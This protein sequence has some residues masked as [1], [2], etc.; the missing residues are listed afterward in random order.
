M[1]CVSIDVVRV[2]VV[3][4]YLLFCKILDVFVFIVLFV[5][6]FEFVWDKV[7]VVNCFWIVE[8]DGLCNI[9]DV[10]ELIFFEVCLLFLDIIIFMKLKVILWL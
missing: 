1:D 6:L 4:L 7:E 3:L 5:C 8:D 2:F 9:L 10:N